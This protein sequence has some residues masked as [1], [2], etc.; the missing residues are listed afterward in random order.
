MSVEENAAL[1][2]AVP[3]IEQGRPRPT[4]RRWLLILVALFVALATLGSSAGAYAVHYQPLRL[5]GWSSG[6]GG[7]KTLT[8]G[9]AEYTGFLVDPPSGT[10]ARFS[11]DIENTGRYAVTLTGVDPL[12]DA[13]TG[14]WVAAD[15]SSHS[16][17]VASSQLRDF[18]VTVRPGHGVTVM[19]SLAKPQNCEPGGSSFASTFAVFSHALG[20]HHR[21]ELPFPAPVYFCFPATGL[22][23]QPG[24]VSVE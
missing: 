5:E 12:H 1:S 18:P 16:M 21:T 11:I 8:D 17:V 19:L 2:S 23:V 22:K 9:A 3:Q 7:M 15:P 20:V 24:G 13:V 10:P 14:H 4:R 6:Q